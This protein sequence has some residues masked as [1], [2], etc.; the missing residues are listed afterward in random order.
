[1]F[2]LRSLIYTLV[3]TFTFISLAAS[4]EPV[5]WDGP[6]AKG[7]H[8][9]R[10]THFEVHY[11]ASDPTYHEL[12]ERSLAIAESVHQ[13]LVPFF[14]TMPDRRTQ[15]VLSDDQDTANGWATFFPFAQIRLYLTPPHSLSGLENYGD[16]LS[17]LIR[18]EYVHI[19]QMEMGR[20]AVKSG[21][22]LF[23]RFPY[24]FPHTFVTPMLIEGLAVY[25]ETDYSAGTG[26]LASSWY[27]M[28]MR[29]EVQS[30]EFA[31][32]GE[33]VISSRDWPYGQYYLYGAFFVEYLIETH[34][35]EALKQWLHAVSGELIPY[36]SLKS[37]TR[38]VYGASFDELWSDFRLSMF[39]RF[40]GDQH[41]V[42][43][44]PYTSPLR[45]QI[46]GS[47]GQA[48][49]YVHR[50]DENRP[51]LQRC[52]G[53]SI[54]CEHLADG[55]DITSI[56]VSDAGEVVAVKGRVYPSGRYTRDLWQLRAGKWIPLT[57]NAR[58]AHA[59]WLPDGSGFLYTRF[60]AGHSELILLS[61]DGEESLLWRG[62]Y[63]QYI[64]EF[65][66]DAAG[67]RI[68]ATYKRPG[69]SWE[70][71]EM[72]L[73]QADWQVLTN[74]SA[75]EGTPRFTGD[76]RLLFVADYQGQFE[77]FE[78]KDGAAMALAVENDRG[79]SDAHTVNAS[80]LFDPWITGDLLWV[81]QY[82]AQGFVQVHMEVPLARG[83][84]SQGPDY[85]NSSDI[86]DIVLSEPEAYQ[87]WSTLRPHYW[88]P[89]VYG[90]Q[91]STHVGLVTSGSDALGRHNYQLQFAYGS[92]Q[93]AVDLN[94]SYQFERWLLAY[95]N[96]YELLDINPTV[97]GFS[98]IQDQQWLLARNW[99]VEAM[100]GRLGLHSGVVSQRRSLE[101]VEPAVI[102]NGPR[103]TE[104][105]SLGLAMTFNDQHVLLHSP[106][107]Y[108]PAGYVV[109]E[110]FS[111]LNDEWSGLHSQLSL[112]WMGDLPGRQTLMVSFDL[113]VASEEA[114]GFTLGGLPP[115]EDNAL[116]GREQLSLRGY[117]AGNQFGR[118]FD[119]ERVTWA[120]QLASI[121]DNWGIWPFGADDL[122][123]RL[124]AERGR[125]WSD[126]TDGDNEAMLGVGGEFRLN[127]IVGYRVQVPV[128]IGI[129]HGLRGA[130]AE[131]QGYFGVQATF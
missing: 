115:R 69:Y 75:T 5:A 108:G 14:A 23:G 130:G 35:E 102:A 91:D 28:Q 62:G 60:S 74:S 26:R 83:Q 122:E 95:S 24:L 53:L 8:T 7:W 12:A 79:E 107:G 27:E 43:E 9:M 82:T 48:L 118:Y 124:F 17:L 99:L 129:A 33:A 93:R 127:S 97:D 89:I 52:T 67:S 55:D 78:W 25:H 104:Q 38:Q 114:P 19:L 100:R 103:S 81:Q 29:A 112:S 6:G 123:M 54:P 101:R 111:L 119:R 84:V 10:S 117:D 13:E 56:D 71:A 45:Q 58:V 44:A 18:H 63:G 34:G 2:A 20:G 31:S 72:K 59:R 125:A 51:I 120:T 21:R 66:I 94:L 73:Y 85:Q 40:G 128:V 49:Y 47:D 41:H 50:D 39:E 37:L 105:H 65:D 121:N 80:G 76:N 36:I 64:G 77:L 1:M 109:V 110:D 61:L 116:F 113:G 3:C 92:E 30:G 87:P 42:A 46:S 126:A 16:W 70:L 4:A 15:L 88:F 57:T 86:D 90:D 68:V 98:V 106:G 96:E 32:L 131:T 22:S 11:P